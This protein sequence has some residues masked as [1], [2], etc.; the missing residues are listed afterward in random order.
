MVLDLRKNG[1]I[2]AVF[3]RFGFAACAAD[4][5]QIEAEQIQSAL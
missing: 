1:T 4:W 2:I 3:G 5:L